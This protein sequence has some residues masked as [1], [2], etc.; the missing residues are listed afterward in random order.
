LYQKSTHFLLELVQNVDDNSYQVLTPTLE[1]TYEKRTLRIDCN[2]IGFSKKNVAAICRIGRSSKSGLD[3][4]RRYIGEKGI[5]FKSVFKVSNVVWIRSG[6]YSFQFDKSK[7]LGM[8]APIWEKF[9]AKALH[10]FTSILLQLSQDYDVTELIR[11][12]KALDPRLLIFLQKLKK[13]NIKIIE[14]GIDPWE[15]SLERHDEP[16]R[17]GRQQLVTL[18]HRSSLLTYRIFR[19]QVKQLPH[20]PKRAEF[21]ESEL[22]LAFP[23]SDPNESKI[24]SQNVYAFLPIR[25]YGFKV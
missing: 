12:I 10:G 3:H 22:L 13:I 18:S 14:G 9:P 5:G 25:D 15:T 11:E 24:E 20:D 7:R 19:L 1:I 17:D 21:T 16:G 23:L 2:E 6:H 4:S 8:I